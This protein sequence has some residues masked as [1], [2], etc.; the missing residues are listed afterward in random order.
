MNDSSVADTHKCLCTGWKC[1]K[2]YFICCI[3]FNCLE[4]LDSSFSL[5]ACL[6]IFCANLVPPCASVLVSWMEIILF[7]PAYIP[8]LLTGCPG[9]FW[10]RWMAGTVGVLRKQ[11]S[12]HWRNSS[13]VWTIVCLPC[14]NW[15]A[16]QSLRMKSWHWWILWKSCQCFQWGLNFLPCVI[17]HHQIC[18]KTEKKNHLIHCLFTIMCW[19]CFSLP[20]QLF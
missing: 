2:T 10:G 5:S 17:F 18:R 1:I 9:V 7:G 16:N 19:L 6:S 11:I 8:V 12:S 13:K 14:R 4:I 3:L 15:T 20:H